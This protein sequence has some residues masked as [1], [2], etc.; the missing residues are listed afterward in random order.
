MAASIEILLTVTVIVK[1]SCINAVNFHLGVYR[2][3]RV[4]ESTSRIIKLVS[5]VRLKEEFE[6]SIQPLC[7][8]LHRSLLAMQ[9]E[10]L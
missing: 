3:N 10:G 9:L 2:S 4:E 5:K 8:T 1:Q 7:G 6:Q